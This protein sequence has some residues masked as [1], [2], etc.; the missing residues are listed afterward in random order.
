MG[1]D[2]RLTVLMILQ[3]TQILNHYVAPLKLI[4]CYMSITPQ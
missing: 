2:V 4:Q 3:Y 1:S